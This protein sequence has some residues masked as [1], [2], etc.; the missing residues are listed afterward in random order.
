SLQEL[1][2]PA[3]KYFT[4]DI[5]FDEKPGNLFSYSNLNFVILGTLAEKISGVRFDQYCLQHILKP[6]K[7][8]ASFDVHDISVINKIGV[9]YEADSAGN[10]MAVKDDYKGLLP[11]GRDLSKY[12]PGWNAMIFAPNGGLRCSA[13][14]LAK[15]M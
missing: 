5:F 2:Q 13:N 10:L 6:L 11:P 9:L 3:G 1:L 8:D 4:P 14:D 7:M 12:I 15:L